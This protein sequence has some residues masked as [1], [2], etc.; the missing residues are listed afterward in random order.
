MTTQPAPVTERGSSRTAPETDEVLSD[1]DWYGQDLTDH[2]VERI[3]FLRADLTEAE[4]RS[5]TTFTDCIFRDAQFNLA[6]LSGAAFLNCLFT[7]CDFFG[8]ELTDCKF[9]GSTF[10]RCDFGQLHVTGGDWS[11]VALAGADL[12]KVTMRGVRMRET[13][14]SGARCDEATLRDLDLAGAST[15]RASF[16]GADLRGSDLSAVDPV[17]TNLAHAVIDWQQAVSVA[18]NLGLDVRTDD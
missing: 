7:G 1:A 3:T 10:E 14:L 13:D 9:V 18:T 11:F 8:A 12:R 6:H 15:E 4:S 2:V 16:A 17:A 5:G